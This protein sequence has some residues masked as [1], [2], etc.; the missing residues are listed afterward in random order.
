MDGL[1][2]HE[3]FKD[4]ER[5]T[6][7]SHKELL[8]KLHFFT[9]AIGEMDAAVI[10]KDIS[11]GESFHFVPLPPGIFADVVLEA[12]CALGMDRNKSF[13]D[14]GCGIG[15]TVLLANTLFD[16]YGLDFNLDLVQRAQ[17][18]LGDRV[19]HADA[20][21]FEGYELFDFIYFYRLVFADDRCKAFEE[22]IHQQLK[23]GAVVAPMYA[24]LDWDSLPD[25]EPVGEFCYQKT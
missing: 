13:L 6:R 23:P 5:D 14:I 9:K 3:V 16:A 12:F 8:I 21:A 19:V 17:Q 24:E 25:M 1:K 10:P 4:T 22:M 20:F 15:T 7:K 18:I 11:D 2:L